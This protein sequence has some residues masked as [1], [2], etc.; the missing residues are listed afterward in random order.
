[1]SLWLQQLQRLTRAH[2]PDAVR[3]LHRNRIPVSR[4]SQ[5]APGVFR[6]SRELRNVTIMPLLRVSTL[7]TAALQN[8]YFNCQTQAGPT[9][10][11][12]VKVSHLPKRGTHSIFGVIF[13]FSE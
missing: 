5:S 10:R 4:A 12:T 11:D 9:G 1:M 3:P 7:A 13:P 6:T 2:H 8:S